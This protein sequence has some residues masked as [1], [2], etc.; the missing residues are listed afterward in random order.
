MKRLLPALA[1]VLLGISA[2]Q[3]QPGQDG[4]AFLKHGVGAR[5]IAMGEAYTAAASDPAAT[6]YNPASLVTSPSSQILLMHKEWMADTR[7]EFLAAKAGFDDF[8]LALSVNATS[9]SDIEIR[10]TPG[11]AL[12]TFDSRN[13]AIGLSAAYRI[14]PTVGIGITAK[15]LYEK[16]LTAEAHGTGID[17]GGWYM[18]PWDLRLAAAIGNL[19]SMEELDREA[20]VLPSM[21]RA[22]A[23]YETPIEAV[24]GGL[25]LAADFVSL[26]HES[27]SHLHMGAELNYKKTLMI[28]AGYQTGYETQA[29]ST[30]LG[31]RYE[32]FAVD[33]A[34]APMKIDF[35]STHTFSL[36]IDFP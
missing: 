7:T 28:R 13:A 9:V 36:L 25:T 18:T 27:K 32:M 30:G 31:V 15:Y 26:S 1:A 12:G 20:T 21:V 5:A 33:Y 10:E 16:I 14:D 4:L 11:P 24:D 34:F 17:L 35:G 19:G 6:Y 3:A 2:T 8:A 22:G 23:T 29:F